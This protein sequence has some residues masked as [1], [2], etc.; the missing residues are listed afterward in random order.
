M[1]SGMKYLIEAFYRS[2]ADEAPP[3]IPYRQ[4]LRVAR[5]MDAIFEQLE[6][7]PVRSEATVSI[8]RRCNECPVTDRRRSGATVGGTMPANLFLTSEYLEK[9]PLWHV[10]DSSWKARDVLKMLG[11]NTLSPQRIA[12]VGCGTGEVLRQLQLQMDSACLFLGYDIAPKAIESQQKPA[13]RST[14]V[15]AGEHS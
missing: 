12:E 15:P 1:K 10:D 9:A 6:V 4:I 2:I 13:E 3:P 7:P 8:G 14:G 11:R 5:I